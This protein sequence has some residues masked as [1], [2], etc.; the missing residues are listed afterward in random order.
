MLN[1][2]SQL[3]TPS[4]KRKSTRARR[5]ARELRNEDSF[6]QT[7]TY[8]VVLNVKE[9]KIYTKIFVNGPLL[10]ELYVVWHGVLAQSSPSLLTRMFDLIN[11]FP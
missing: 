5:E 4:Q 11:M 10:V 2:E 6:T 3:A 8:K 1:L 7:F 9:N